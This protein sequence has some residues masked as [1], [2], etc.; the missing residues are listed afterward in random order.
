MSRKGKKTANAERKLIIRLHNNNNCKIL[1]DISQIVERHRSTVQAII[2]R[3]YEINTIQNMP[4]S[5]CP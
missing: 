3:H 2:D 4:V 5:E 1:G